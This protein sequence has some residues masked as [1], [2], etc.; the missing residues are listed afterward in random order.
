MTG[1]GGFAIC[2]TGASGACSSASIVVVQSTGGGGGWRRICSHFG[3]SFGAWIWIAASLRA[4]RGLRALFHVSA[5][6]SG[7]D[8]DLL[9]RE[10]EDAV[11]VD[12]VAEL[13]EDIRDV[14]GGSR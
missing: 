4:T 2:G 13:G 7:L 6:E 9:L 8:F 12:L 11:L 10:V 1:F 3:E 5:D 14:V